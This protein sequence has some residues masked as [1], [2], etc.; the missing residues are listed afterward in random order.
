MV[1]PS[2]LCCTEIYE[3]RHYPNIN[4]SSVHNK[5]FRTTGELGA[6]VGNCQYH[7]IGVR[8]FSQTTRLLSG[9]DSIWKPLRDGVQQCPEMLVLRSTLLEAVKFLG[10][11]PGSVLLTDNIFAES[12]LESDSKL[13][14][15]LDTQSLPGQVC[16][17]MPKNSRFIGLIESIADEMVTYGFN[18]RIKKLYRVKELVRNV[19]FSGLKVAT[20]VELKNLKSF[21]LIFTFL[22]MG[23]MITVV[24]QLTESFVTYFRSL[25]RFRLE[26]SV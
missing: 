25:Q 13:V 19:V 26:S 4:S 6:L 3:R 5:P 9:T 18:R 20:K 22:L 8:G 16:F 24:I 14:S 23:L 7:L 1:L 2:L 12:S 21:Y 11:S 15:I 17:M 10:R